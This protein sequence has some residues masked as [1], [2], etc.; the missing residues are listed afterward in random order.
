VAA[1]LARD[2]HL[3][4][5]VDISPEKVA[6]AACGRPPVLEPGLD[7]LF[8]EAVETRQLRVTF[9][10]EA[11]VAHSEVSI[12][13]VGTPSQRDGRPNLQS[14][15]DVCRDIGSALRAT[16]EYHVVVVRST[17]LPGT[18]EGHVIPQLERQSGRK[19]GADFGVVMNPEFL[20]EGTALAD[21]TRPALV[22]I[23]QI[24]ERSGDVAQRLHE[25]SDGPSFRT[26]IRAAEMIKYTCNAFH[27]LKVAFANEID[28]FC[29]AHGVDGREL[30]EIF[31]EDRRLNISSA[32]LR[33]GF[34][35]GGSCLPKD[36]RALTARAREDDLPAPLLGAIL[37][38]N[39]EQISRAIG[40]VAETGSRRVGVLGLS[41]KAGTDD[42]RESPVVSLVETLI[43]RGYQVSIYDDVVDPEQLTGTNR[44]FLQREIPHIAALMRPSIHAVVAE[45]ETVV[46]ANRAEVFRNVPHLMREGQTLIDLVGI[47]ETATAAPFVQPGAGE[48]AH[49]TSRS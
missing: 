47:V 45:A 7:A 5:G 12:I 32:Y 15:A 9:D 11:A 34:A 31:C 3:V 28:T 41:F 29:G 16:R 33:P 27:A 17:V 8:R 49:S 4:T 25:R 13:C 22:V 48:R 36:L 24:D 46:I 18:V 35:F 30:M 44:S 26:T 43:G 1:S 21:F 10:A 42:V 23:G 2:R 39:R 40:R 38:S 6:E 19:A 14:L 20:R 37:V